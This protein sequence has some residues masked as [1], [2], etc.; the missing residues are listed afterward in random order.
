MSNFPKGPADPVYFSLGNREVQVG[1]DLGRCQKYF[2]LWKFIRF[3]VT[4]EGGDHLK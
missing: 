2:L 1:S 4:P 3:G